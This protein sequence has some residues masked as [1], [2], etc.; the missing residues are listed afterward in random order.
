[1]LNECKRRAIVWM[2]L[3]KLSVAE[4]AEKLGIKPGSIAGWKGHD[5]EFRAELE[6]WQDG[7]PV[8]RSTTR[9]SLRV[10]ADELAKR[11]LASD[12]ETSLRDLLSIFDRVQKL[13]DLVSPETSHDHADPSQLDDLTPDQAARLW[14]ALAAE[15]PQG[16]EE[17]VSDDA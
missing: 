5:P 9:Q 16:A 13:N 6:R 2:T 10:L 11:A 7:P 4:T 14:A 15:D 8:L 12:E 17:D 1:M 3:G